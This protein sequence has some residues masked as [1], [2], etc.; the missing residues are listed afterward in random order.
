[1]DSIHGFQ[2]ASCVECNVE[3][4]VNMSARYETHVGVILSSITR[5]MHLHLM[6]VA[7]LLSHGSYKVTLL[8]HH[9]HHPRSI[10][11]G[12]KGE[13]TEAQFVQALIQQIPCD[14]QAKAQ[15]L[16]EYKSFSSHGTLCPPET[17]VG[18]SLLCAV[19][20]ANPDLVTS[21]WKTLHNAEEQPTVLFTDASFYGGLL[22]AERSA[23]PSIVLVPKESITMT[24][25][26]PQTH[27]KG[28][29]L[30]LRIVDGVVHALRKRL[31]ILDCTSSFI[32]LNRARASLHLKRLRH[33]K[34]VW[35]SGNVLISM[36]P[37]QD[38][39]TLKIPITLP[40]CIPCHGSERANGTT[41]N[42][43]SDTSS[44]KHTFRGPHSVLD[45]TSFSQGK[46]PQRSFMAGIA[47]AYSSIRRLSLVCSGGS[48]T[49]SESESNSSHCIWNGVD[50]FDVV[51]PGQIPSIAFP[52][53]YWKFDELSTNLL[54]SV[55]KNLPLTLILSNCK[56]EQEEWLS[57]LG[58][59]VLCIEDSPDISS[60]EIGV[61]VIRM[62]SGDADRDIISHQYGE[63]VRRLQSKVP[64]GDSDG[65]EWLLSLVDEA[66]RAYLVDKRNWTGHFDFTLFSNDNRTQSEFKPKHACMPCGKR[67][68]AMYLSCAVLFGSVV[69]LCLRD[70]HQSKGNRS[71]VNLSERLKS[72]NVFSVSEEMTTRLSELDQA[73]EL[74]SVWIELELK[75]P[76]SQ[77]SQHPTTCSS[78]KSKRR[79]G[80]KKR[81]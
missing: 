34:E 47:L 44:E 2:T 25:G 72:L 70:R 13:T 28:K 29:S 52:Q 65:I 6:F 74:L 75:G 59:P 58:T 81:L 54:D 20:T 77:S 1:M 33:L 73:V 78:S 48:T 46:V 61:A 45:L 56:I 35:N 22:I 10:N 18:D 76:S 55:A 11:T 49:G 8:F 51:R 21:M 7:A 17:S 63:T 71:Q 80:Q 30:P 62:L 40:I 64:R 15:S 67:V 38:L 16:L 14:R 39:T 60:R 43:Q 26:P 23:L 31:H 3:H 79:L 9:H 41:A 27:R 53:S 69:Y 37:V 19:H 12:G 32:A 42:L 4:L 36:S 5:P 57:A 68:F 66:N 24:H 50:T